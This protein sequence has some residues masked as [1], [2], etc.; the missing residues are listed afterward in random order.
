MSTRRVFSGAL[1]A[2]C[3]FG[4]VYA[5]AATLGGI[6][7]NKVG[8]DNV[9]IASCDTDGVTAAYTTAWDATDKR[10]EV[11]TATVGSVNDACD[12][13]TLKVTLTD[14]AG[15]SLGEG[16]LS[17]PSS[18][19]TSFAVTITPNISAKLAEGIHAVIS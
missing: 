18:A 4:A 1:V 9:A 6:T 10:Y 2:L 5:M 8:A 12:G 17:I 19:A 15:A 11:S 16:T 7:S 13:E 14:S 3:A